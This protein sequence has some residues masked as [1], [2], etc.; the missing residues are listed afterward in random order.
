MQGCI[1]KINKLQMIIIFFYFEH[2]VHLYFAIFPIN[3]FIFVISTKK[4]YFIVV[5]ENI[6]LKYYLIE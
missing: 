5:I 4:I 1:L 3:I 6:S 2:I